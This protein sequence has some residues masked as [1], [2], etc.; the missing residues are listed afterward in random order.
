L[1]SC[2]SKRIGC[3]SARMP[4]P[5]WGCKDACEEPLSRRSP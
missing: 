4:D 2:R 3:S 5:F 1:P